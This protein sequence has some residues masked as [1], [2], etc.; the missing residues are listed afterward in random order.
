MV[1]DEMLERLNREIRRRTSVVG[2]FS[3]MDSYIRL[4]T[5]YLMSRPWTGP[6]GDVML[7]LTIILLTEEDRLQV[8]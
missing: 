2:I 7:S 5:T 3:S 6:Q 4:V 1:S 8:A